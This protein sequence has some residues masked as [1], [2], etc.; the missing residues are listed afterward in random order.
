MTSRYRCISRPCALFAA[1]GLLFWSTS[2]AALT[3][4]DI[5]DPA[6]S[7][8]TGGVEFSN[9]EVKIRGKGLSRD[10]SDHEVTFGEG[11][12]QIE[13]A[14]GFDGKPGK[15]KLAYLATDVSGQGL[16]SASLDVDSADYQVKNKLKGLPGVGKLLYRGN[17]PDRH[18]LG[19]DLDALDSVRVKANIRAQGGAMVENYFGTQVVTTPEPASA[20][21]LALGLLGVAAHRRR[22]SSR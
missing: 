13:L 10:L 4:A 8:V 15:V 19:L 14:E 17:R 7:I 18:V 6:F 20:A 12:I 2:A 11:G 5:A 1:L 22:A 21:L 16:T 9:F 3:L